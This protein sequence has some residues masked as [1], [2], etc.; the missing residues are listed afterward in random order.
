MLAGLLGVTTCALRV[1]VRAST[2]THTPTHKYVTDTV[3][4]T[5]DGR[6]QHLI[7]VFSFSLPFPKEACNERHLGG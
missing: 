4:R 3:P 2:P 5:M 6:E 1:C 7:N